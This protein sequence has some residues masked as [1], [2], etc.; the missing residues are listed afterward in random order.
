MGPVP[1]TE[2][3]W[4]HRLLAVE[5]K[6]HV[7]EAIRDLFAVARGVALYGWLFY[8]LFRVGEEHA[9]RVVEAGVKDCY[10]N[11]GGPKRRPRFVETIA[12]LIEVDVIPVSD[13]TRWDAVRHL[14]NAASHLDRPSYMPPGA[15][16]ATFEA[17]AHDLNRL[18]MR[19]TR[20]KEA[21][22]G[23]N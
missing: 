13:K 19:A 8:P 21:G 23:W 10:R 3:D 22:D 16:L 2:T 4:A 17:C 12:W 20:W 11:L 9:Y 1:L 5:L 14:R 18:F 7:P 6:E 15:V